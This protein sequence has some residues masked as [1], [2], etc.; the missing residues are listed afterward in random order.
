MNNYVHTAK[1]EYPK[2]QRLSRP[3]ELRIKAGLPHDLVSHFFLIFTSLSQL[4]NCRP[5]PL[6]G[7]HISA[8]NELHLTPTYYQS[9]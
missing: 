2:W 1:L 7:Y 5:A 9:I 4:F 8:S 3:R 6:V